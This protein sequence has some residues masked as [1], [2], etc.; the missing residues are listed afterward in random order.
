MGW[1][2]ERP[3]K[4]WGERWFLVTTPIWIAAV[5]VVLLT[6]WLRAWTDAGYLAF[7]CFA[8]APA[9]IGPLATA[10]GRDFAGGV[11]YWVKLNLY[12]GIL[13]FFGTYVGT[14]YFFDLMG[15]RY[16]FPS[17]WTFEALHVGES[18]E[19]VPSFMYPLT[20]AYFVT[21][22]TVLVV[23]YRKVTTAFRLGAL[24]RA[25]V[26][27]VLAYSIAFA[28]TFF[29]ATD[30]LSDLFWYEKKDKMLALG[31]F[32][33][34][35]YFVVGLPL[36]RGIDEPERTPVAEVVVRALAAAMAIFFLLEL[37]ARAIGRL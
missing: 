34:A 12:A 7:S 15:M 19:R 6:G 33:Y 35:A 16:A 30:L 8:A 11:P 2:S 36:A 23:A 5:A 32:G 9:A 17:R 21:Y 29:M 26:V 14:H 28:E 1:L 4:A 31:S 3:D 37:W 10:R 22:F 18:G 20:Q 13:V 25:A 24:A 27:L